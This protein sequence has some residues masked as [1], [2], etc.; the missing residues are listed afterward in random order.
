MRRYALSCNLCMACHKMGQQRF[1]PGKYMS[2]IILVSLYCQLHFNL[3]LTG[4][5]LIIHA[6]MHPVGMAVLLA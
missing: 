4:I 5:S 2:V 6:S 1:Q 3:D